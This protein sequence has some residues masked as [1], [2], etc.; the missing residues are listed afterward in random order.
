MK[1]INVAVICKGWFLESAQEPQQTRQSVLCFVFAEI[2][3]TLC[4]GSDLWLSITGFPSC[5]CSLNFIDA[6]FPNC[7]IAI[8]LRYVASNY[9]V[10]SCKMKLFKILNRGSIVKHILGVL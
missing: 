7:I 2:F 9:L 4:C 1:S 5:S 3:P 8:K 6:L 10:A